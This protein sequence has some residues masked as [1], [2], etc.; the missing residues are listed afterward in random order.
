MFTW[1]KFNNF[2]VESPEPYTFTFFTC[3][4]RD[5]K[6]N[7]IIIH[8][9]LLIKNSETSVWDEREESCEVCVAYSSSQL[10]LAC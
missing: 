10:L 5:Y 7:L 2:L 6:E 4:K 9:L 3:D 1:K 8:S